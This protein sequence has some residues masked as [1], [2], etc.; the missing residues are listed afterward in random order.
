MPTETLQALLDGNAAFLAQG[1]DPAD[2]E[3]PGP[4][5]RQL[6]VVACMDCRYSITRVLGLEHGDAK[7]IRSAGAVV[8]DGA[9]RSLVVAVHGLGVRHIVVVPHTKCGMLAVGAG[10]TAIAAATGGPVDEVQQWLDGFEDV[11]AHARESVRRIRDH[12]YLPDEVT[13]E[14]LVYD[15]ETGAVRVVS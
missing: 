3:L 12:P 14:A 5:R 9:L 11:D 6:A 13:V 4:P 8:D 2:A 1:W 7:I 10:D 15:N